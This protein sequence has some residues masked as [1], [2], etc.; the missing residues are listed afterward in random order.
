[1]CFG[2]DFYEGLIQAP[3]AAI[4]MMSS[5][6]KEPMNTPRVICLTIHV[7]FL[8]SMGIYNVSGYF[9]YVTGIQDFFFEYDDADCAAVVVDFMGAPDFEEV[10]GATDLYT[11]E[12]ILIYSE[13]LQYLERIVYGY[14]ESG[15][16]LIWRRSDLTGKLALL[17]QTKLPGRGNIH[18][19]TD[20]RRYVGCDL[21][22]EG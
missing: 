18:R 1:M 8:Y 20:Q 2:I 16:V 21:P 12:P 13:Y 11:G 19:D 4:V 6:A 9:D 22:P 14:T 7:I 5:G 10:A 15:A 17:D 3:Q